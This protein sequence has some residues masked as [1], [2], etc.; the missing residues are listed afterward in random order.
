MHWIKEELDF[1]KENYPK[2]I[3]L[4]EIAKQLNKSI[5]SIHHKAARMNLSRQRF[6][7]NRLRNREPRKVIDK[8]YYEK[9]KEEIYKKRTD[10]K[11]KLKRE[12]IEML[13]G[14]CSKCG[15]NKC[16]AAL[17]FHHEGNKEE[18]ITILL[19][20]DSKQRILKEIKK[21]ILLCAN[22]HRELH[23]TGP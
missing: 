20:N 2:K 19:K 4:N 8:K 18:S 11:R 21:C 12:L 17:D 14:K 1:L 3:P 9:N 22:C 15:Y 6:L 7:L 23:Y 10:R 5:K 16:E 13:G